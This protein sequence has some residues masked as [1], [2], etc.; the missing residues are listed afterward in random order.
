MD[1][2]VST[3]NFR[4]FVFFAFLP[5]RPGFSRAGQDSSR[6]GQDSSRAGQDSSRAGQDSSRAG[7]DFWECL[8]EHR[9]LERIDVEEIESAHIDLI[10][11]FIRSKKFL[12][13]LLIL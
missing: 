8:G 4:M 12:K 5:V 13:F 10:K 9:L 1:R 11:H 2:L 3:E 7:W 6:A